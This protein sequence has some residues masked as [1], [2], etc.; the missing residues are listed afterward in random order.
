MLTIYFLA[1]QIVA[2]KMDVTLTR[3]LILNGLSFYATWTTIAALLNISIVLQYTLKV[4]PTT[5]GTIVLSVLGAVVVVYY[6]L[7]TTVLKLYAQDVFAV[8]PVVI[9][10]LFVVVF[11]HWGKAGEGR[12][13]SLALIL[14]L[15]T[16]TLV[17]LRSALLSIFYLFRK[18]PQRGQVKY[19]QFK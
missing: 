5:V 19:N 11:K 9:W 6:F 3:V 12:N 14:L 18:K 16:A 8:Y 2:N 13:V 4:N 17:L 15:T 7:E 1:I 10:A